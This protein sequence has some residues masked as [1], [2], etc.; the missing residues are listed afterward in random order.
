MF[1]SSSIFP[2][3]VRYNFLKHHMYTWSQ[4]LSSHHLGIRALD[5][6][7][8]LNISLKIS[9]LEWN[10]VFL[11]WIYSGREHMW[12]LFWALYFQLCK[13][14]WNQFFFL[15]ILLLAHIHLR[16]NLTPSFLTQRYFLLIFLYSTVVESMFF[17]TKF[18]YAHVVHLYCFL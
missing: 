1:G 15:L 5:L 10:L 9:Y 18:Y 16:F 14:K 6:C 4:I 8:F 13:L 3:W 2:R 12:L 17:K 11:R 7:P